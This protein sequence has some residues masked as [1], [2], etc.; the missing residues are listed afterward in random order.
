MFPPQ[1]ET[2]IRRLVKLEG[3]R[4]IVIQYGYYWINSAAEELYVDAV[5]H[6]HFQ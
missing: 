6:D 2:S 5:S 3:A 1:A 4:N